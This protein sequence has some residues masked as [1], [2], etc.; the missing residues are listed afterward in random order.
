[1]QIPVAKGRAF[2]PEDSVQAAPVAVINQEMAQRMFGG[3]DPVGQ[4]VHFSG[5]GANAPWMTPGRVTAP[6]FSVA[7]AVTVW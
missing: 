2:G 1:M 7:A 6:Q 3:I 4:R 5:P